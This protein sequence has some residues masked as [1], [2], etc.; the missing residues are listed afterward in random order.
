MRV[1]LLILSTIQVIHRSRC[2]IGGNVRV[3]VDTTLKLAKERAQ[4][5]SLLG[6]KT[7]SFL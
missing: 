4:P 1:S 3:K 2:E 7:Y 5:S 6:R